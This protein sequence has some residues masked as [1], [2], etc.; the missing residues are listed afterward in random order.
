LNLMTHLICA[1]TF[2]NLLNGALLDSNLQTGLIHNR[3]PVNLPDAIPG[4]YIFEVLDGALARA[5]LAIAKIADPKPAVV[6]QDLTFTIFVKNFGRASTTAVVRDTFPPEVTLKSAPAGCSI[7]GQGRRIR[8]ELG[9]INRGQTISLPVVVTPNTTNTI[10]NT[11]RVI[12]SRFDPVLENNT[13]TANTNPN[14][15][16]GQ[17]IGQSRPLSVVFPVSSA[18]TVN[19]ITLVL[20]NLGTRAVELTGLTPLPDEQFTIASTDIALP[21]T[22]NGNQ[23][24]RIVV[25]TTR[26]ASFEPFEATAPYFSSTIRCR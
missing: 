10:A 12:G 23:S 2:C 22:I 19:Q 24:V 20:E 26:P 14:R 15:C 21:L 16:R 5:D 7:L 6:G 3:N 13:V 1:K 9:T 18:P 8:C 25:T 11:A 4:R 17:L